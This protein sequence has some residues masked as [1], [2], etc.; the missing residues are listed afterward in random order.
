MNENDLTEALTS[1]VSV[2]GNTLNTSLTSE[3][4]LTPTSTFFG[5]G[6]AGVSEEDN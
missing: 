5:E 1:P 3:S 2:T 4:A 6:S